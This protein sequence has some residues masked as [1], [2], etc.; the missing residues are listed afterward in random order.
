MK[1]K[2]YLCGLLLAGVLPTI[3]HATC[4]SVTATSSL[5]ATA[6]QAGYTAASW[7]GTTDDQVQ[8]SLGLPGVITLSS[9]SGFQTEGTLLASSSATFV[10][11]GRTGGY[12]ASQV[13]F[14]CDVAD[15]GSLYEYYATNGDDAYGGMYAVSSIDG[16]YYTYVRNVAVR[17]TN[18]KTGE[19]YSRLWK[20]REITA[21]DVFNDG[22]YIYVPASAFSDVYVELFKVDS[23]TYGLNTSA[24]YSY[25]YSGP[26]GY[27]AFQG[28]GFSPALVVGADSMYNYSGW[29]A[30]W[31][32]GWSLTRQSRFVRGAACRISDY[33]AQVYLP[34]ITVA[35]LNSGSTSQ[36]PFTINVECESGAKSG[37]AQ[38]T[39]SSANVAMGF[40]V[41]N[42]TAASA[43]TKLG[44]TTS[45]G[46][47]TWLL[48]NNYGQSGV[49]SGVGIRIYSDNLGSAP[50]N[51]LPN[52]VSTA[53]GNSGG[54]YAY[55]DLTTLTSS[56][57]VD[58]YTGNFT[59]SLEAITGQTVTSGTVYAQLQVLV[60]FQ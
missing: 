16:A 12:S 58:T 25:D 41:N 54:W 18:L 4:I 26:A 10:P 49:A 14:R 46:A 55:Q 9:G 56:G 48:D 47:Y 44:L 21:S 35:E 3:G 22:T 43:A 50:L 33:P 51:L 7:I 36:S 53:T 59:A 20:R 38:S 57:S 5:S 40:L 34:T 23:T 39:A 29:Y 8:G 28:G 45:S 6:I 15:L 31:A 52:K 24:S 1:L 11:S 30:Q 27:I 42:A 32:G 2:F 60:S 17:L 37:T 13:L 19:Y